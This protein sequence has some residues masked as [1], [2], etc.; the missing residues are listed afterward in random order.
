[1][2]EIRLV[3]FDVDGTLT[4]VRSSWQC[5]HECLGTWDIGK[6]NRHRFFR[7]EISYNEW[8]GL[9]ASLWRGIP[10][11]KVYELF[12]SVSLVK[13]VKETIET[14]RNYGVKV[15]L[16]SAGISF[17]VERIHKEIGVDFFIANELEVLGGYL[18]GKVKVN[19][20]VNNKHCILQ[21]ILKR[22]SVSSNQCAAV[23]DDETLIPVFKMVARAVAFNPMSKAVKENAH[24]VIR[25]RDLREILPYVL[26]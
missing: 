19:L 23:G 26:C 16:L 12:R 22:F 17:L 13:G 8:A 24:V 25:K 1:M 9:D 18:T 7:G 10:V 3:V 11:H 6:Q 15:V 14:L 5:L 2:N 20:T 4:L 21:K